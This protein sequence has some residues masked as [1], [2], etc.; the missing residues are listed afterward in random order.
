MDEKVVAKYWK[1]KESNF[2][3]CVLCPHTCII[4]QG[5]KGRCGARTNIDGV[6][7][8]SSFGLLTS[9]ALDPIEKKP[10]YKFH[11]GSK[12]VSV[13]SYGCN[14]NCPFCQNYLISLEYQSARLEKVTEDILMNV[15]VQSIEDG[16]IGIAFT[17]NEPLI[18]Y[19]FV[20][21][22]SKRLKE[23]GMKSVL[24]TNGFI[25]PSPLKELLP[26]VDAMNIDIKGF[27][28][29]MYKKVEGTLKTVLKTVERA[30]ETCHV[31]LT[32]LVVPGQNENDIQEIA[33]WIASIDKNIPYHLSR[34]FPRYEYS[35]YEP[36][37]ID[38]MYNA[39]QIA[40]QYLTEVHLG[41]M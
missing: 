21:S 16:N 7:Y 40:E 25:N 23:I 3:E 39:K 32:T 24:V 19:E 13:G 10:L 38:S 6:L 30:Y 33:K 15:A 2:V 18:G 4:P 5:G 36:T 34:F 35:S 37:T 26:Y 9:Y 28:S 27:N 41:N 29:D 14:F 12:I 20:L 8:A 11:S 22:C 17:Y 31:E 1:S